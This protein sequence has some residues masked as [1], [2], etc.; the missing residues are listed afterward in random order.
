MVKVSLLIAS[1]AALCVSVNAQIPDGLESIVQSIIS[2]PS[3][4]KSQ[5]ASV[6]IF[7]ICCY[8]VLIYSSIFFLYSYLHKLPL[9]LL[10]FKALLIVHLL[11][12]VRL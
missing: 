3:D 9:Y 12:L 11:L 8:N 1:V 6:R 10:N 7:S 5:I 2:N 4:F